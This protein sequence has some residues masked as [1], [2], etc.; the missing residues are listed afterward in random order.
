MSLKTRCF[1]VQLYRYFYVNYNT[2]NTSSLWEVCVGHGLVFTSICVHIVDESLERMAGLEHQPPGSR[3]RTNS[4]LNDDTLSDISTSDALRKG[5][6]KEAYET[7]KRLQSDYDELLTKY[8]QAENTIDQL[9]I[10]AKLNLYSDLPPPQKGSFVTVTA[11]KQPQ[12]LNFQ[13]PNQASFSG[14]SSSSVVTGH[15]NGTN[16][17]PS[18]LSRTHESTQIE[19]DSLT[20]QVRA[21]GIR[22]SLMF[23]LPTLQENIEDLQGHVT[24]GQWG[25]SELRE[26]QD[27][28]HQLCKQHEEM[29]N[30]LMQA[31]ELERNDSATSTRYCKFSCFLL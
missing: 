6:G 9:R 25:Q 18:T 19:S 15:S 2:V 29:K 24:S 22:T 4:A 16:S 17:L 20:P 21:D 23:K 5:H 31:K 7:Y 26:L 27:V 12:V 8:A 1:I 30:E 3:S 13:R 11:A 28:C 14:P 10:G